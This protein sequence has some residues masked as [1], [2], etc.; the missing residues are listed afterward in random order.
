M[1]QEALLQ[2]A[3]P[4]SID[5]SHRVFREGPFWQ[6]I[7]AYASIDEATF[8]D[9]QWQAKNS[10]V[11]VE[12]L[13][14][15]IRDLVSPD[16]YEDVRQ[17]YAR[18]PMSVRVSPYIISLIDWRHAYQDPLRIQFIPVQSRTL[19]DHPCTS[20]DSLAESAH[21]PVPGLIHRYH[22]KVLFLALDTCPVYC[23]FCTRSYAVGLD[24]AEVEK[25]NFRVNEERWKAAFAYLTAHPEVEDVVISGGDVFQLRAQ[26]IQ[27]IGEALLRIPHIRRFRYA[28]KGLAVMPQ[29]VLTDTPWVDALSR[30]VE[31][32]QKLHKHVVIHT[33]F[34]HPH[35]IT[36]ITQQAI[37]RLLERG[38]TIRNQSV[39]LRG[40]N[41]TIPVMQQLVKRLSYLNV[42]PYYVFLH[43]LVKGVEDLRTSVQTALNLEPWVRGLTA[44][45]STPTFV[46][47]TP[48]GGGKRNVLS[49]AH[50][51]RT[52]G[53]SVYQSPVVKPGRW[54]PYFDPLDQLPQEGQARWADPLEHQRMV[55]EAIVAA[56]AHSM[57]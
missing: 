18:A 57:T 29:K 53:I 22:D 10:I 15:V 41:D 14:G 12:Q 40:V 49:F 46:V 32:G 36:A 21:S 9:A 33:H 4:K 28:T 13:L 50:Y 38:V 37:Q 30:V 24:T 31:Q 51:D 1:N 55:E 44:G 43:D 20:L 39:L 11:R 56:K 34:N 54:F 8:L 3:V 19:P 6:Q 5:L 35:E 23:R 45:F 7:P 17:G 47:D 26:Q 25:Q 52:T 27:E 16:F 2:I 48:G 42:H